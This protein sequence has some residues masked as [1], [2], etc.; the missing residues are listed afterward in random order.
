MLNLET[1][2]VLRGP[3]GAAVL[4][5]AEHAWAAF[6][7]PL[8]AL[9]W[10]RHRHERALAEAALDVVE[11]RHRGAR[12]FSRAAE[13]F[14]TRDGYEQSSSEIVA[15][16]CAR[17]FQGFDTVLDLG[18]GIG[19]DTIALA[20]HA[21]V[22]A[23][24]RDPLRL[25]LARINAEVYGL[26]DRIAFV[27]ADA[28]VDPLPPADAL[29]CDPGRRTDRG[30]TFEPR[31]YQPPLDAVLA[32]HARYPALG[33][34]VA[35]GIPDDAVPPGCEVEFVQRDGDL[36]QATLWL[37][38]LATAGRRATLLPGGETM[39]FEPSLPPLAVDEP[40]A[41][42]YEPEPAAIRAHL[43]QQLGHTLDGAQLDETTAFL[44]ADEYRP[45]PFAAAFAVEEWL[46]FNLKQL[47]ARL[48]LLGVG[49]VVVK[50][51]GSPLDPQALE[52]DL[53]LDDGGEE[54]T[55]VLTHVRGRHSAIICRR[56]PRG[57][58]AVRPV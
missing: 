29:F 41:V 35:P 15:A 34:K 6:D 52:R 39:T 12:K 19:G 45:T 10:M 9:S 31:H 26:A 22:I 4:A 2:A 49:R 24:D 42:L 36:K 51:R 48:R 53:R 40:R 54:R 23:V 44:T 18:C 1:L 33:I 28:F 50:K 11:F 30:R 55:I 58:W 7:S 32:L 27:E 20:R 47:R 16:H 46:P 37:G 17:R 21:R 8:P 56:L 13:M 43:V 14:F 57:E 25:A 3:N 38:P 5:D